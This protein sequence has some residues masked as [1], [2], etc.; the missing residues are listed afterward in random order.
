MSSMIPYHPL[1]EVIEA[2]ATLRLSTLWDLR[3]VDTTHRIIVRNAAPEFIRKS[4][5]HFAQFL[6]SNPRAYEH[7][8]LCYKVA[9]RYAVGHESPDGNKEN[10]AARALQ[11]LGLHKINVAHPRLPHEPN[12]AW[13]FIHHSGIDVR[14][15]AAAQST[16]CGIYMQ[17]YLMPLAERPQEVQQYPFPALAAHVVRSLVEAVIYADHA[18]KVGSLI[19][20]AVVNAGVALR[21]LDTEMRK[22]GCSLDYRQDWLERVNFVIDWWVNASPEPKSVEEEAKQRINVQE[23]MRSS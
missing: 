21:E 11:L 10:D 13:E 2:Y 5:A 17:L 20:A 15:I 22:I 19:S 12:V 7:W 3:H 18:L 23:C 8:N 9:C 16:A 14:F 1:R 4:N 6:V